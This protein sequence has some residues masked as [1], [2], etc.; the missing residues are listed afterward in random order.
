M[1]VCLQA[2]PIEH[3]GPAS[4]PAAELHEP[5]RGRCWAPSR[6]M[7]DKV[8]YLCPGFAETEKYAVLCGLPRV[9]V[10]GVG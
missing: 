4:H 8:V 2:T 1:V 3:L 6:K 7:F 10:L 9:T 5:V